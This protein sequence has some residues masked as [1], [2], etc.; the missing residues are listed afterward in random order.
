MKKI[1]AVSGGIDSVVMLHRMRND[2]DVVVAHFDHG[3]RPNSDADCTFVEDLARQYGLP[4][5]SERAELGPDCSEERART[6]RYAFLQRL[7]DELD[8]QIYTAHHRDDVVETMAINILR[9]TGWR[10]IAP[11]WDNQ[12]QRPLLA[13]TK[14]DIYQYATEHGLHFRQDQTNTEDDYL[15]NRV[16][17][18][19]TRE[20][21]DKLYE[22]YQRQ[23]PLRWEIEQILAQ[24]E[25]ANQYPKE[26]VADNGQ[27]IF[28]QI[29]RNH[30]IYLT[31][32]QL[33]RAL[34][35]LETY[36]PG[37]RFSLDKNHYLNI[38]RYYFQIE[39]ITSVK[40]A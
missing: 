9:G 18:A 19:L 6:A 7:A 35:A 4:F 11:F 16:R 3:I 33:D 22:I 10:G 27:E 31:R 1:L 15:R 36:A 25:P 40:I 39:T 20:Q 26:L 38:K 30:K 32:P 34:N 2:S 14:S 29:L 28:R 5:Y 13:L 17:H 12:I 8:G 21:R 37:K 24:I 23:L